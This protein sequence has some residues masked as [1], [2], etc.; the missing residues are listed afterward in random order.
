MSK[1]KDKKSKKKKSSSV[2]Y[3]KKKI[4]A[5]LKHAVWVHYNGKQFECKCCVKWCP[6][7]ISVFS[8]EAGHDIPESKGGS[9]TIDNLRPICSICNRSMS[10]VYTIQEF[11]VRFSPNIPVQNPQFETSPTLPSPPITSY[12]INNE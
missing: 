10:N 2:K 8:F 12:H 6:N 1:S 4:P 3:K 7:I 9:T 5:S 11:S